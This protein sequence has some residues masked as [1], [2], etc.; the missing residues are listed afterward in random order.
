MKSKVGVVAQREFLTTVRRPSYVIATLGMPVF[1]LLIAGIGFLPAYVMVRKEMQIQT[2]GI[3][4][5]S[6][7]LSLTEET[8][9]SP[10]PPAA[11]ENVIPMEFTGA[12]G[13]DAIA[14]SFS[15]AARINLRPFA[16]LEEGQAALK[17]GE[18]T[19]VVEFPEPF[20]ATGKVNVYS[21][22]SIMGAGESRREL[23]GR[24]VVERLLAG[25]LPPDLMERVRRPMRVGKTYVL[26]KEG[27]F[28]TQ[29][30]AR[31]IAGL[32]VPMVFTVLFFI[33][34]IMSSGFLLQGVSEEKENRVI[35]VILSSIDS[36]SLLLGKLIG[37]GGAG[38]LQIAVWVGISQILFGAAM[39][40]APG[41]A[42]QGSHSRLFAVVWSLV[43]YLLGYLLF[44]VLLTGTGSL[45]QNLKES[46][47][48]GM[49]WSMGSV[50]PM[51]MMW[52]LLNDPNGLPARVLSFVPLTAPVT[53]FLRLNSTDPPSGLEVLL[54]A[55]VLAVSVWISLKL[56]AKIF[57]VG[58]LLYGKRPTIPE[59]LKVLRRPAR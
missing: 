41:A 46:Q 40:F 26:T 17:R 4:D 51:S 33:S 23:L 9:F 31:Q 5:R 21:K 38:L 15:Q 47:Q 52:V 59:I 39:A 58:L 49:M 54:I 42:L 29:D 45:G 28:E 44:G 36:D 10:P 3:V 32:A 55:G 37:L 30:I 8:P 43:F 1:A 16:S 18:I 11:V 20:V 13:A 19:S 24:F 12:K 7:S 53:M 50:I 6:G 22:E 56:M 35:E 2:V 48:Y 34:V 57:R 27:T 25:K 14:K